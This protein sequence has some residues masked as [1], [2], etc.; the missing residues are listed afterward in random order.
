MANQNN[1]RNFSTQTVLLPPGAGI[2]VQR[3]IQN[4]PGQSSDQTATLYKEGLVRPDGTSI[5]ISGNILSA[6]SLNVPAFSVYGN[7][8]TTMAN[9][10]NTKITFNLVE[11]DHAG[12][13]DKAN[14]RYYVPVK[15][16]YQI[17]ATILGGGAG[18][19][20]LYLMLFKN[21]V[22]FK[23]GS[24]ITAGANP[25]G[26]SWTVELGVGEYIEIFAFQNTGGALATPGSTSSAYSF[27]G[28]LIK[29]TA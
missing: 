1:R 28:Y 19:G 20:S 3:D 13:F 25:V 18:T 7:I 10:T 16:I 29:Q 5:T 15:G 23:Y 11:F 12:R 24:S 2:S 26:G 22:L 8:A 9:N 14:Y 6:N 27:S 4:P 17:N 21:G